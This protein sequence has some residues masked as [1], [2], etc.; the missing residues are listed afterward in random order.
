MFALRKCFIHITSRGIAHC[1]RAP[2]EIRRNDSQ[3]ERARRPCGLG[4]TDVRDRECQLRLRR[5]RSFEFQRRSRGVVVSRTST[6]TGTG[7]STSTADLFGDSHLDAA[8]SQ[9]GRKCLDE[10]GRLPGLLRRRRLQ[11]DLVSPS[12]RRH[13]YQRGHR[14]TPGWN[15][16]LCRARIGF[17]RHRKRAFRHRLEHC[18]LTGALLRRLRLRGALK[19]P[20]RASG[21]P[22]GTWLP[23]SDTRK[24]HSGPGS[25]MIP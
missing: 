17:R 1:E 18:P 10:C 8:V 21:C 24:R 19:V 3:A 2:G 22:P 20:P 15:A 11:P 13:G 5:R 4:R 7:T 6:S 23:S 14:W 16:L 25:G 12:P 9:H